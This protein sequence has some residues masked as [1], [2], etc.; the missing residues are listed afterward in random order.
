MAEVA[1]QEEV[2]RKIW[3]RKS[4]ELQKA[5]LMRSRGKEIPGSEIYALRTKEIQFLEKLIEEF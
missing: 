5:A 4:L 1:K 3:I 2:L